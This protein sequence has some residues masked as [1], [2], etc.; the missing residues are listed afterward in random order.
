MPKS[1]TPDSTPTSRRSLFAAP[2]ALAIAGA[3]TGAT[4]QAAEQTPDAAILDLGARIKINRAEYD[5]LTIPY[6]D[7][8]PEPAEN[9]DRVYVLVAEGHAM[10]EELADFQAV[11]LAGLRAKAVVLL[12]YMPLTDDD[13]PSWVNHEDL[14][15]WSLARDLLA[16]VAA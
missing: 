14:M 10:A 8:T 4:V 13:R 12:D 16:G 5:A 1:Y 15:G 2:V 7:G 11:T 3:A 6:M 9:R